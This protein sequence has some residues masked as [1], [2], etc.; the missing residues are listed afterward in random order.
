MSKKI[1]IRAVVTP[2]NNVEAAAAI[3]ALQALGT[4]EVDYCDVVDYSPVENRLKETWL[5]ISANE[6]DPYFLVDKPFEREGTEVSDYEIQN[7]R[8]K[9]VCTRMYAEY[10][11]A[12][13]YGAPSYAASDEAAG[14]IVADHLFPVA[15]KSFEVLA[16][17]RRDDGCEE[18]WLCIA[19]P[20]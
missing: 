19:M 3:K 12:D 8:A 9:G 17:D 4:V 1:V 15:E 11:R 10:P 6:E 13:R 5:Y 16:K 2:A 14:L 7:L 18:F 20:E